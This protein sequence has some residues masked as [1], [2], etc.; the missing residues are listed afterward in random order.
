MKKERSNIKILL[1]DIQFYE[2]L[3]EFEYQFGETITYKQMEQK[4][5]IDF[6]EI[7]FDNICREIKFRKFGRLGKIL[8]IKAEMLKNEIDKFKQLLEEDKIQM[9]YGWVIS[10]VTIIKDEKI[11]EKNSNFKKLNNKD[12][13]DEEEDEE[14]EISL[15]EI[16]S[17]D[18]Y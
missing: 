12:F 9:S 5:Y 10:N 6:K 3:N 16:D 15:D 8:T 1:I 7:M 2:S 13:E 14:D 4:S 18:D 11:S 17:F